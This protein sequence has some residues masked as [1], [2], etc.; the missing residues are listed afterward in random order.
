MKEEDELLRKCGT[1]NPFTVPEGY[2]ENFSKELMEKLPEKEIS[3]SEPVITTWQRVKPWIYMTA[4]FCGLML[5]VRVF[6][7]RPKQDT[8][9][10]TAAEAAEFSDEYIETIM[11]HSMM[12]DYTLY[13]YLTEADTETYNLNFS[14]NDTK[15]DY[16]TIYFMPHP[17][18]AG[19]KETGIF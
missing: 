6:V 2:F 10:F 13:Q 15:T 1:K 8:P 11:E 16:S 18:C 9:I 5:S 19:T 14:R 7:G 17:I 4:M 3:L 12:D